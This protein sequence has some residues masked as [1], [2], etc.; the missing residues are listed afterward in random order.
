MWPA[1]TRRSSRRH[2]GDDWYG[3]DVGV[4]YIGEC[5]P[6]GLFTNIFHGLGLDDRITFRQ[7]DPDGFWTS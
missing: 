3:F 4:H 7:L 2:H 5:G 6:G 1:A